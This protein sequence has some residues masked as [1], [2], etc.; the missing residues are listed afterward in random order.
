[1]KKALLVVVFAAVIGFE[2]GT[3]V[4]QEPPPSP[5]VRTETTT[6][7]KVVKQPG[8]VSQACKDEMR[9]SRQVTEQTR[10]VGRFFTEG[11]T[12]QD[13][14]FVAIV[15]QDWAELNKVKQRQINL[16]NKLDVERIKLVE[17]NDRLNKVAGSCGS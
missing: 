4:S 3:R 6:K 9:L 5:E 16:M 17:M 15:D 2:V 12:I 11:G 1:M 14:A 13:D 7:I 10:K 8:E